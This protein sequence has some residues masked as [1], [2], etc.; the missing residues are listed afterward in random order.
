VE[1]F[2]DTREAGFLAA[3]FFADLGVRFFLAT[4]KWGDYACF[5]GK[6]KAGKHGFFLGG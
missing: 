2:G 6:W 4:E 5:D 1:S 3:C